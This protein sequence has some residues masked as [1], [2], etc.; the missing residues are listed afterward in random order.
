MSQ[1]KQ[2]SVI[3]PIGSVNF[4]ISNLEL[5]LENKFCHLLDFYLVYDGIN[6]NEILAVQKIKD[7]Y[8]DLSISVFDGEFGGPGMAR[9]K[10]LLESK[11][12]L[13]SFWDCD[14]LPE[15]EEFLQ[16]KDKLLLEKVD[17]VLGD[18]TYVN[19]RKLSKRRIKLKNDELLI[20]IGLEPG[21]WRFVFTRSSITDLEFGEYRMGEDQVFLGKYLTQFRSMSFY[22]KNVYNYFIGFE[23]QLTGSKKNIS[24]IIFAIKDTY[25]LLISS[26]DSNPIFL[27]TLICRQIITGIT[28]GNLTTK[29]LAF[30]IFLRFV[31]RICTS[32]RWSVPIA[33]VKHLMHNNKERLF[34][35]K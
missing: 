31:G 19:V 25:S 33:V 8:K 22:N 27:E 6:A 34:D 28:K 4:N 12:E 16:M 9:N 2:L 17:C 23:K 13:I 32:R 18:F 30:A 24:E 14:D 5:T 1:S 29:V 7:K 10:G 20:G 26:K 15:V 21:L 35:E 11:S 3:I